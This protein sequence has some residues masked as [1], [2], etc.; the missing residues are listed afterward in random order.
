MNRI[1]DS[2]Y[3]L[4]IQAAS[5]ILQIDLDL[6]VIRQSLNNLIELGIYSDTFLEILYPS[7]NYNSYESYSIFNEILKFLNCARPKTEQEAKDSIVR[8]HLQRIVEKKAGVFDEI[9]DL[10]YKLYNN[11]NEYSTMGAA[12]ELYEY[13]YSAQNSY[14][15]SAEHATEEDYTKLEEKLYEIALCC[16]KKIK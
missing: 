15:F 9:S 11:D 14:P 12:E 4:Y 7:H 16:L 8:Y 5:M 13:S 1:E 6:I 3:E 2:K 10:A